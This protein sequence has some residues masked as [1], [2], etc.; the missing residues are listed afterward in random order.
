MVG[1][2]SLLR[3][4]PRAVWLLVVLNGLVLACWSVLTPVFHA[5]D[6][7]NH[8]EAVMRLV[9]G[10]GW[11]KVG[12]A[13]VGVEGQAAIAQSP[14]ASRARPGRLNPG[15]VLQ[16]D[17]VP[18]GDRPSWQDLRATVPNPHRGGIQQIVQHPPGYYWLAAGAV[19]ITGG[20]GQRWDRAVGVMRLV[21]VLLVAPL[22][23]LAW[24][25]AFRLLDDSRA[26]VVAA[27][28]PLGIPELTHIGGSVNNDNA[29]VFTAGLLMVGL[30]CVLR[31]DRRLGTALFV[32]ISLGLAL[33]SKGLALV[34]PPLVLAAYLLP[35]IGARRGKDETS[36]DD[37]ADAPPPRI[38]RGAWVRPVLTAA[39]A[40]FLAGG[41]WF[42]VSLLRYGSFQPGIAGF[43]PGKFLGDDRFAL[44][45]YMTDI[46][47]LRYW[48]SLGWFEVNLPLRLTYVASAVVLIL[49]LVAVLRRRTPR[50]RL[51]L[52]LMLYPTVATWGLLVAQSLNYYH[53]T[54][55][56]RGGSGRYLF[57]GVVGVAVVVG[58]GATSLA[59]IRNWAPV[60]LLVTALGMQA[61]AVT[62]A[63]QKWWQPKG[64]GIRQAWGALSSWSA[65][66]PE[67][68]EALVLVTALAAVA[69]LIALLL[70]YRTADGPRAAAGR[71]QLAPVAANGGG[72]R[73]EFVSQPLAR[74]DGD[75]VG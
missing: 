64:G 47:L 24:A 11:A 71:G 50:V 35:P 16:Q 26:A 54:H 69:A 41:W 43:A 63:V 18:R 1:P 75:R 59:R 27:V 4:A 48:G 13:Y 68:I 46:L 29:L 21:S 55:Y 61:V 32:G 31:G 20:D 40:A 8:A 5:P 51:A 39:V 62:L 36:A 3:G 6:E 70:Q 22:P 17:A 58:A 53:H 7:P 42:V 45:R 67:L 30:A 38:P 33:F 60:A 65:W 23:L 10:Q 2:L 25:A 12:H 52:L 74:D 15:P 14:F 49:V 19:K 66:P 44:F 37:A 72:A 28:V 57:I 73:S 9:T 56:F 34:L